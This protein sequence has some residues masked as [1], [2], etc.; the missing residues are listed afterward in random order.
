MAATRRIHKLEGTIDSR[1]V[2]ERI[3]Y[4][5]VETRLGAR[6]GSLAR[7]GRELAALQALVAELRDA[8]DRSYDSP[9]DGVTL[10]RDSL[11]EDYAHEMASVPQDDVGAISC[12]ACRAL[13][14]H[15]LTGLSPWWMDWVRVKFDGITYWAR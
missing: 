10:I 1:D 5:E 7:E 11:F 6:L 9:E 2:L 15:G 3:A 8:P 4:L 14:H 12:A 13:G